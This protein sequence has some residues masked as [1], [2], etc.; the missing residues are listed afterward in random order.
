MTT[1]PGHES[2]HERHKGGCQCDPEAE[3]CQLIPAALLLSLLF[4]KPRFRSPSTEVIPVPKASRKEAL[5][6]ILPQRLEILPCGTHPA[7]IWLTGAVWVGTV[8]A[9]KGMNH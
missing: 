3:L 2:H 5:H 6:N 7:R 1:L 8:V 4:S 9:G